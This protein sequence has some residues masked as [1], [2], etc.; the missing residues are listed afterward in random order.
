MSKLLISP[1]LR[2]YHWMRKFN[3]KKPLE[4]SLVKYGIK[5]K[6]IDEKPFEGG[7]IKNI[8]MYP[9]GLSK[10]A[11]LVWTCDKEF[12]I[13]ELNPEEEVFMW[14]EKIILSFSGRTWLSF[15]LESKGDVTTYQWSKG[16]QSQ[17][18]SGENKWMDI[19]SVKDENIL[20]QQITNIL[21][22]ILTILIL[23]F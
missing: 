19:F 14:F 16:S 10:D 4:N 13:K 18:K 6:N 22:I 5:I 15:D 3:Y 2:S 1:V 23:F 20:Q 9:A 12:K 7:I 8:A 21:L 11:N 17:L